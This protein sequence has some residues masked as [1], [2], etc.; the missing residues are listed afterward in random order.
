MKVLSPAT[1][2]SGDDPLA[3]ALLP[4]VDVAAAGLDGEAGLAG[5]VLVLAGGVH[6]GLARGAGHVV[7]ELNEDVRHH[8]VGGDHPAVHIEHHVDE[9][10]AVALI[11]GAVVDLGVLGEDGVAQL[12]VY[13][14][15][16]AAVGVYLLADGFP[17]L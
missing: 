12:V 11:G 14:V 10:A 17:S 7:I 15:K 6:I 2:R 16:R 9:A 1:T 3:V 8:V 13:A 5:L 4:L